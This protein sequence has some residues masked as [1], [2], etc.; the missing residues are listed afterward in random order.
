MDIIDNSDAFLIYFLKVNVF[1]EQENF[2]K[3]F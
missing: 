2:F 1:I 3:M